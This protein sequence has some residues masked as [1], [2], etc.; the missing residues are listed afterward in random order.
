MTVSDL[1]NKGTTLGF[2]DVLDSTTSMQYNA[3]TPTTA[4]QNGLSLTNNRAFNG[5]VAS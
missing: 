4:L 3:A 2:S 1:H 5:N